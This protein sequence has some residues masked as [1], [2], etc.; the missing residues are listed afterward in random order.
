[1]LYAFA[2]SFSA[3]A[4]LEPRINQLFNYK[5]GASHV[6]FLA[7]LYNDQGHQEI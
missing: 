6:P 7:L 3:V 4:E 1:M 5:C 2:G